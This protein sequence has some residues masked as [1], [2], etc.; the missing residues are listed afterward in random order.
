MKVGRIAIVGSRRLSESKKQFIKNLIEILRWFASL[1]DYELEFGTG[2]CPTGADALV[3]KTC[4]EL[5][6]PCRVFKTD[7]SKYPELGNRIYYQRNRELV[8]WANEVWIL[9]EENYRGKGSRM[10]AEICFDLNKP[11]HWLVLKNLG[12]SSNE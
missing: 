10:V 6:V 2:D 12:E 3:R 9:V 4:A 7:R 11:F 8:E 5:E 1:D